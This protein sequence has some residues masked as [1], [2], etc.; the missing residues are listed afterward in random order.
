MRRVDLKLAATL[1][2][3]ERLALKALT[4]AVYPPDVV[5]ASPGRHVT[6]APTDYSVLVSTPDGLLV[7]HVGILVRAGTLDGTPVTIG[8]VG[9]VK[10][11]PRAEGRGH[12]SAGLRHAAAV[13]RDQ[14]RVAFS[15]LACQDHLLPFYHRLGWLT[16]GGQLV[17][18]QPAGRTVFTINRTM[19]LSGLRPAPQEGTID[20]DGPP[21]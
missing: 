16:F 15:L 8:G 4:A 2:D 3:D 1:S 11:H 21:W 6:W 14:H 18:T 9:G 5:A 7:S 19:V 10:T 13:L 12:A 20:L 17:V